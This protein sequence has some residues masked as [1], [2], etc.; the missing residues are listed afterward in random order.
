MATIKNEIDKW[1]PPPLDM[2]HFNEAD[3]WW[4]LTHFFLEWSETEDWIYPCF[5]II[6]PL[7]AIQETT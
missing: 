7:M 2:E 3:R 6:I 1:Q 4:R 5:G